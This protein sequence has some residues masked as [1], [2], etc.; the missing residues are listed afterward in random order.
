MNPGAIK[1][2]SSLLCHVVL[3]AAALAWSSTASCE[4]LGPFAA[5]GL[6][7]AVEQ[8]R[9]QAASLQLQRLRKDFVG[10][11][12][13]R[14]KWHQ[15]SRMND[16]VSEVLQWQ[17]EKQDLWVLLSRL[18]LRRAPASTPAPAWSRPRG[19]RQ[20]LHLVSNDGP[21][22]VIQRRLVCQQR[23]SAAISAMTAA[24]LAQGW[25]QGGQLGD[26]VLLQ[27]GPH[28]VSMQPLPPN[29]VLLL[30]RGPGALR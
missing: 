28:T 27:L 9:G 18:D 16:G 13:H 23:P 5:N 8:W 15:L 20:A 17:G 4:A 11:V 1:P 22:Q 10:P 25:R 24:A 29:E 12:Q 30:Q 6:Q 26:R 14:G 2:M 21:L 19:C 7:F 3:L